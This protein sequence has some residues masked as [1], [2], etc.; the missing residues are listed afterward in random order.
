[1]AGT[2]VEALHLVGERDT[3]DREPSGIATSNG[4]PFAVVLTGTHSARLVG[5]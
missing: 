5:A 4:Y 3:G 2:P 1:M